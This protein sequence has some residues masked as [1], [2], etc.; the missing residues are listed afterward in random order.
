MLEQLIRITTVPISLEKL[1]EGQL[2]FMQDYFK[3]VAVSGDKVNLEKLGDKLSLNTYHVE[4]SRKITPLKD[5]R[6]TIMLYLYFIRKKPKIV[7]THTP[8]AGTVGILAAFLAGVPLRLHTV[9]GLPLME[10]KGSKRK[11]LNFVEKLTYK[12]ATNIYPNSR[13]LLEFIESEKLAPKSKLKIIGQGSSNGIDTSYFNRANVLTS[14]VHTLRKSLGIS[15][16]DFV[17]V[18]VGRLVGDKGINELIKSFISLQ[19][20]NVKLLLVGPLESHLDPLSKETLVE[21]KSNCDIISV[22][23]QEDVR[24][25]FALSNALVFPSYRE[26]FP[27]VVMQAGSMG[28]PSIVTDINGCN[29]IIINGKNGVI[30]PPKNTK[31]LN[32]AMLDFLNNSEVL[33]EMANRSRPLIVSRFER[34]ELWNAMLFEYKFLLSQFKVNNYV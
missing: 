7:H 1:L 2:N 12:L 26:G 13:G 17:F 29:E 16:D 3:V 23:Y 24:P 4:M 8:K 20:S 28:L 18:F 14:D 34:R 11:L 25:Y 10:A 5:L 9:A 32:I 27:N 22:G 19:Q 31:L 21:I 33:T 15:L 30:I 6:A